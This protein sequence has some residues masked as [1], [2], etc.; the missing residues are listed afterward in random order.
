MMI[1][2]PIEELSE[3]AGN[4]YKLCVVVSKRAEQIQKRNFENMENPEIKE[5]TEAANELMEGK[6]IVED[7]SKE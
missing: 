6:M 5:I 3:K 2:P 1:E 7:T 4:K